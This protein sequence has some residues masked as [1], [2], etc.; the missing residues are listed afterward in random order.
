MSH[1]Y[2]KEL[3]NWQKLLKMINMTNCWLSAVFVDFQYT[4]W[5][6]TEVHF[7][8][9]V[10]QCPPCL[11][12]V[13]TPLQF[14]RS[15]FRECL[16][17]LANFITRLDD[18]TI[19][20]R[21]PDTFTYAPLSFRPNAV[22]RTPILQSWGVSTVQ[23]CNTCDEYN[24][25]ASSCLISQRFPCP[26]CCEFQQRFKKS[27]KCFDRRTRRARCPRCDPKADAVFIFSICL[28]VLFFILFLWHSTTMRGQSQGFMGC[29]P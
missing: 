3:V 29:R 2:T 6:K 27:S 4:P 11:E 22:M 24:P 26:S 20:F 16:D 1:E 18:G 23:K 10:Q 19:I 21:D 25:A 15:F 7:N 9:L 12:T 14:L 13:R 28:F 5:H 17:E 8:G